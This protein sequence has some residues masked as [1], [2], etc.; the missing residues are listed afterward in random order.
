[1]SFHKIKINLFHVGQK[2]YSR[3]KNIVGETTFNEKTVGEIKL[4]VDPCSLCNRKKSMSVSDITIT[5]ESS[6]DFHKM[7]KKPRTIIR[8]YSTRC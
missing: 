2:D 6:G 1:M 8:Y 3:T 7:Y 5:A 4:L